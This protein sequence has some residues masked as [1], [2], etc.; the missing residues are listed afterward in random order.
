MNLIFGLGAFQAFI[1][2][3]LLITKKEKKTADKFLAGFFFV[4]C[5]YLLNNFSVAYEFW[6]IF[7]NTIIIITLVSLTYGPLLYFYVTSLLGKKVSKNQ[8]LYH[9]IP[10]VITFLI[11]LP[12]VFKDNSEKLPYFT[13]KFI[14]LPV[15]V[16]IGTFLQF[17]SA[18]VYFV[19]IISILNLHKST[20]KNTHSS[21]DKISLSWMRKLLYG[22]VTIWLVDCLFVLAINFTNY[23]IHY[24][25]SFII[26]F[27]FIA[28]I[29][30]IGFYG[31]RQGNIFSS[32]QSNSIEPNKEETKVNK[33]I[34][35]EDKTKEYTETL[36]RF[37]KKE[38][39]YLNN[40]IRI[41]DLANELNIP[42]HTLSHVINTNLNQNFYD[43][44]NSHRINEVKTRLHDEKYSHYTIVAIAFDCGFNSK[45]TFNRLFKQYTGLTPTQYKNES[46]KK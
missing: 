5:L 30:L 15:N 35:P 2:S 33:R 17:L 46:L 39:V 24:G 45:A 29:I 16:A 13:D 11:I 22:V 32:I 43:F 42:V 4:I 7:P 34:I 37:M 6:K 40:E 23:D 20:L 26:K 27:T 10:I 18:P 14:N 36:H 12:F 21:I 8:L 41:Q 9:S 1:F 28:F 19:W 3:L 38:K 44:I 31:I 25:T